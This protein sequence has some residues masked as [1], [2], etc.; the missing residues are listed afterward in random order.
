M[1]A[2]AI[3]NARRGLEELDETNRKQ[4]L[5]EHDV[6]EKSWYKVISGDE[7][8]QGDIIE[9]CPIYYPPD[10]LAGR[11]NLEEVLFNWARVT[12]VVISQTCD[13]V[14]GRKNI[15]QAVLCQVWELSELRGKV[16]LDDNAVEDV[17]RGNRPP[18]HMLNECNLPNFHREFRVVD[19]RYVYTL[20]V[21]FLRKH[22]L[23]QSERL[24]LLSPYKEHLAQS[25]A[26]FFMRV[27]LPSD[28]PPFVKR[29]PLGGE[30]D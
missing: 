3:D 21:G 7:L 15:K 1:S 24:R 27:G 8:E 14:K 2:D 13:L 20:P 12:T 22:V 26:Q 4:L 10:D 16:L 19:F 28:I 9:D 29:L 6:S 17:R 18:L 25:F 30:G 11:D 5:A 23:L